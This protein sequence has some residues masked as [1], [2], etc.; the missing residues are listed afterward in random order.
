MLE[1]KEGNEVEA[2]SIL[3]TIRIIV[4]SIADPDNGDAETN[5]FG[6]LKWVPDKI[7]LLSPHN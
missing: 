3:G 5:A 4:A 2:E 7:C 1:N 6:I